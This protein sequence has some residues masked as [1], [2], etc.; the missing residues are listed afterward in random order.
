MKR[1]LWKLS[2]ALV[3]A[4]A[5][6][7]RS[8]EPVRPPAPEAAPA[9]VVVSRVEPTPVALRATGTL[10]ARESATLS[11]QV[12][13][14]VQRVLVRA[15]DRVRA[16]QTLVLL[17][18]AAYEAAADQSEAA[19]KAAESQQLA[20]QTNA[21][22]AQSTLAR[23][24][25]LQAQKSVS[26][27]EMDEVS[28]RAE[29]ASAQVDALKAQAGA[30][31]AQQAAARTTLAY[32]HI[33]APFSGIVTARMVDPG[34][35]ASPGL[36]L[37]TID[38]AGP[39][40]LQTT[41]A[42]SALRSLRQGMKVDVSVDSAEPLRLTGTVAEIVPA[43]DPASHS[44]LIKIDL[45]PD[46]NLRAGAYATAEIPTGSKPAILVP[47][48]AIVVRGSLDCAYALDSA[49]VAQLRYV[50]LGPPHGEAVEV[51]SGITGGEKLV[52]AP[53]DRDL[54]GKR[55]EVQP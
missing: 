9:H 45:P 35:V 19:V 43:A 15:G 38:S 12:M 5:T 30:M 32:T 28:R 13:G 48:S 52:D 31:R 3:A 50:T 20:A 53:A 1:F 55:I 18:A 54:A 6:G 21:G 4:N 37:L 26:P 36:P 27:Q 24:Q 44:F 22:L 29:A 11:A 39:L 33:E 16:G 46:G 8:N 23:Y 14:R 41:V 7:C 42:E 25:Q 51:L 47:R 40:Q 34:V 2:L 10:H 49:G 17:D